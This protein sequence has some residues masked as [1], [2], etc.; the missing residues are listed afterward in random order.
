[1]KEE[2]KEKKKTFNI[3]IFKLMINRRRS[4]V[5]LQK[6]FPHVIK[7]CKIQVK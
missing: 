1:L 7:D 6:G 5:S 3:Q 4:S 2:K